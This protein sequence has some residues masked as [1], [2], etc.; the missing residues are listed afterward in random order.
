MHRQTLWVILI[1]KTESLTL[2][3]LKVTIELRLVFRL[4]RL[5]GN[6]SLHNM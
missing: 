4:Y 2:H 6:S 5:S 1:S 3:N